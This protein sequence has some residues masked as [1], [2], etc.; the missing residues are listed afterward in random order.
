M[1]NAIQAE[2]DGSA[3]AEEIIGDGGFSV[4]GASFKSGDEADE[5]EVEQDSDETPREEPETK[6][7]ESKELEHTAAEE[8]DSH[9]GA[10]PDRIRQA[11]R[12]LLVRSFLSV[13]LLGYLVHI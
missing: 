8:E 1:E 12:S 5:E 3:G 9:T 10:G 11:V 6:E 4:S 7:Q 13:W 2:A